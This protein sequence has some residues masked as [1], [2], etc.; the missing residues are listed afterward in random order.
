MTRPRADHAAVE[1]GNLRLSRADGFELHI[2]SLR[3]VL[4][5][6]VAVIGANGSGKSSLIE[7]IAGLVPA[8]HSKLD[9]LGIEASEFA[10]DSRMRRDIG[11]QLQSSSWSHS[12]LVSDI[13]NLHKCAY[14]RVSNEIVARLGVHELAKR[15]Y[16]SL[17][18]G[19]RRRIDVAVAIAHEPRIALLDEP[20]SGLD[21]MHAEQLR[22][23]L[24][25]LRSAGSCVVLATHHGDDLSIS[26]SVL[27]M[28][29]GKV[30]ECAPPRSLILGRIGAFVGHVRCRNPDSTQ[31]VCQLL[32]RVSTRVDLEDGCI[33]AF[34]GADLRRTLPSL[35]EW[36]DVEEYSLRPAN[37]HDLLSLAT[38]R[39]V[40]IGAAP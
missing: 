22:E 26:D 32:D 27:W 36:H 7:A 4:Q 9:L 12:L 8:S 30:L 29:Q 40:A 20:A 31:E 24:L 3:I 2:D 16:G 18:G 25:Q 28:S 35:A 21:C 37:G 19:Q 6:I 15:T 38:G 11:A 33:L 23:C 1:V 17:S 5:S 13:L 39:R 10:K 34:G 14:G